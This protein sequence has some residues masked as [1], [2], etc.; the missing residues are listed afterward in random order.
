MSPCTI[1][2]VKET[3]IITYYHIPTYTLTL[4]DIA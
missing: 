2:C 3:I 4:F 1:S